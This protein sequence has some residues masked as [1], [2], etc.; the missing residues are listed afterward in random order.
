MPSIL[1]RGVPAPFDDR[2]RYRS[3]RAACQRRRPFVLSRNRHAMPGTP[4]ARNTENARQSDRVPGLS[5]GAAHRWWHQSG[6]LEQAVRWPPV[7]L[8]ASARKNG[9][10]SRVISDL[11][12]VVMRPNRPWRLTVSTTFALLLVLVS[13]AGA[14]AV[15]GNVVGTVTDTSDA[16]LPGVLVTHL[17]PCAHPGAGNDTDGRRRIVSALRPSRLP[18]HTLTF[19]L[20][21]FQT[22]RREGIRVEAGQTF[23][24]DVVAQVGQVQ[25]AVTVVGGAPLIDV[26]GAQVGHTID[27]NL[28]ENLPV[29][30]RFSDLVEHVAGC[31]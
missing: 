15:T 22:V 7:R 2:D 27:A 12:E 19:E 23:A 9:D 21:G 1:P 8:T 24:V 16:R 30:R 10:N 14:Q 31:H 3:A 25:Q 6:R 28:A 18:S 26:K 13:L 17:G 4:Y 5:V 20:E 11:K 29:T